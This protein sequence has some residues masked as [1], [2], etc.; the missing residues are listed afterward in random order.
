MKT[1]LILSY[2]FASQSSFAHEASGTARIGKGKAVIAAN[3]E[4]GIQLSTEAQK[5]IGIRLAPVDQSPIPKAAIVFYQDRRAIYVLRDN[6]FR[7][8]EL[9]AGESSIPL[10]QLK[11][12]DQL[13]IDGVALLRAS[14]LEAFGSHEEEEEDEHEHGEHKDHEDE[15][16]HGKEEMSHE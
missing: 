8:I 16:E 9:K 6:F 4:K 15:H 7:R 1:I 14:E 5:M 12:S 13:V 10:N 3:E 11:A 2:F